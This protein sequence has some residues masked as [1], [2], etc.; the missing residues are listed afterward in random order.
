LL[1]CSPNCN[2]IYVLKTANLIQNYK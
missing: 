2:S 1:F